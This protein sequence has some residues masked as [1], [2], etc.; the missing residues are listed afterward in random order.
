MVQEVVVSRALGAGVEEV[1]PI[2]AREAGQRHRVGPHV[3]EASQ[4]GV[5]HDLVQGVALVGVDVWCRREGLVPRRE[6]LLRGWLPRLLTDVLIRCMLVLGG[7]RGKKDGG[8]G[9]EQGQGARARG[10]RLG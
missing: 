10:G 2:G 9:G 5:V 1:T 3:E 6:A 8:V 4:A 7:D